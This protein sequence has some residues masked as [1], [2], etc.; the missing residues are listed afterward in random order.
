MAPRKVPKSKIRLLQAPALQAGDL[1][2][3]YLRHSPGEDQDIRSQRRTVTEFCAARGLIA[4]HWWIDE[5]RSGSTVEDRR[6]FEAMMAAS[7]QQPPP[8][9]AIVIRDWSRFSRDDLEAQFFSADLRLRGYQLVSVHDDIPQGEFQGI[10]ESFVRWKNWRYLVDLQANV[11]KGLDNAVFS[12]VVVDGQLRRG[13]SGG[14]FPPVGYERRQVQIGTKPSG[15]PQILVYWVQ[16]ADPD[17]RRRVALA[18]E[19]AVAAA[20]REEKPDVREI[21]RLCRLHQCVSSYYD[22][23]R[24]P[25]YAGVRRVGERTVQAAHEA[26]VSQE[27]FQMVQ[28]HLPEGKLSPKDAHPKRVNSAFLLS[29]RVFCGY[30]GGRIDLERENRRA[31]FATLRCA[32]RKKSSSACTLMKL[33]YDRFMDGV[34][35]L[36]QTQVLTEERFRQALDLLNARLSA[37]RANLAER[38]RQ[39]VK[40][41]STLTRAVERLLDM[42]ESGE[43]TPAIKERLLQREREKAEKET[44]LAT[45]AVEERITK[46]VKVSAAAMRTLVERLSQVLEGGDEAKLKALLE[47]FIVRVEITNEEGTVH[48]TVPASILLGEGDGAEG[49][50]GWHA[51]G[52]PNHSHLAGSATFA[53]TRHR[54]SATT[55]QLEMPL[56]RRRRV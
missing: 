18:W 42:V 31:T 32:T 41:I 34:L 44:L 56:Q 51:R 54:G 24:T 55:H 3:A 19:M 25:T 27:D 53:L 23:F 52:S 49:G 6:Q 17:L 29:G 50:Y 38:R 46:P 12:E 36:L 28:K 47:A 22:L 8:V 4:A 30:C 11:M 14:G 45:M 1:V 48:Y 15:K 40:E 26:Y 5:A 13:F 16:T 21:H 10:F 2:W 35:D 7:R 43:G 39:L 20:R 37:D 9:R 33:S